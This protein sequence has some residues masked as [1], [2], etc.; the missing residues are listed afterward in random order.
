MTP[1]KVTARPLCPSCG[2]AV[3]VTMPT[4]W[5]AAVDAGAS[6]PI[7]GCGNPW[8]YRFPD[9]PEVE[10]AE[11]L[12]VKRLTLAV[13]DICDCIRSDADAGLLAAYIASEYER[14]ET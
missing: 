5:Q 11:G 9:S 6:V 13:R 1:S 4:D 14:A 2:D 8:H 12:D 10:A 3:V 7:V